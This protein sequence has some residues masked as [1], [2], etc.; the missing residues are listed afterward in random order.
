[1][2]T[3]GEIDRSIRPSLLDR[4]IDLNPS[5]SADPPGSWGQSVR[6]LKA[7]LCR[8]LEWL[9]NSR[10]SL[11]DIPDD[12]ENVKTS[13]LNYGIIDVSSLNRD[14]QEHRTMLVREVAHAIQCYEPR[15]ANVKVTLAMGDSSDAAKREIH[16]V[17]EG[18]LRTDPQ[19]EHVVFD[20][21]LDANSGDYTVRVDGG[22][23]AGA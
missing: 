9:L 22:G 20:T 6:Q 8:D 11:I 7:G 5:L 10:R 15:L 17:V 16:F 12:C 21:V 2:S 19:P 4:L 3:K 1:M 18:L 23:G 13:V 14:S